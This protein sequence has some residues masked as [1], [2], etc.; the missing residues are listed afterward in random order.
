MT[1]PLH[2]YDLAVDLV[3]SRADAATDVVAALFAD[4]RLISHLNLAGVTAAMIEDDDMRIMF[5]AHQLVRGE[6]EHD[7]RRRLIVDGLSWLGLWSDADDFRRGPVWTAR[8]LNWFALFGAP[9][10]RESLQAHAE[11]AA[12]RLIRL[13]AVNAEAERL[14]DRLH[15]LLRHATEPAQVDDHPVAAGTVTVRRRGAA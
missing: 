9:R 10:D 8:G 14:A 15:Q 11:L 1:S 3:K 13:H 7:R 6:Q 12:D 5:V 4:P 2:T